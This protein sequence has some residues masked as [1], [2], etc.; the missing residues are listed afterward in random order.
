MTRSVKEWI[1]KSDDAPVPPRV[2]D[3]TLQAQNACC[4]GCG[5]PFNEKRKPEFDHRIAIIL[6]GENRET[7][8]QALCGDC[9]DPKTKADTGAKSK[10]AD[11]RKKRFQL[12]GP[13]RPFPK[14]A[15]PWGREYLARKAAT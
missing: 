5:L 11:I 4:A 3:R 10:L 2:K 8:I 14:R 12:K 13:K 6:G 15:D 7:N 1:A 9:H